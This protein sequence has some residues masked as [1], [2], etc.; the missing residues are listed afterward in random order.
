M[1]ILVL[2]GG[3]C[4]DELKRLRLWLEPEECEVVIFDDLKNSPSAPQK[5]ITEL[6]AECDVVIFF[7]NSDLPLGEVQVAVLAAHA[8][9]KRIISVQLGPHISIEAF[10]KYGSASIPF[11]Q[12]LIVG[13]VCEDRY[14]WIDDDGQP[15]EEP[16]TERHKCK[17]QN[18]TKTN[19]AA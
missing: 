8:K 4:A 13:A 5:A 17:K 18:P 16:D 6:I 19:A 3:S 2:H 7:V 9:G 15:R 10:E 12:N 11:K 1:K 14:A